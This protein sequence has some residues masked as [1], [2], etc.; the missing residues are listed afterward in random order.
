MVAGGIGGVAGEAITSLATDDPAK[1]RTGG[2]V[3][4]MVAGAAVGALI[5]A[6]V[7]GIGAGPG[8]LI[9]GAVGLATYYF[10]F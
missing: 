6:P 2:T 8:A 10:G 7:G 9:G 1:I 4:A 5:G 3:G